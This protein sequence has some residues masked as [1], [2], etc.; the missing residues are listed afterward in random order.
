MAEQTPP[1]PVPS[2]QDLDDFIFRW[3]TDLPTVSDR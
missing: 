2:P 1:V 3:D